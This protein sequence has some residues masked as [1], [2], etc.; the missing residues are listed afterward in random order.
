M[1]NVVVGFLHGDV[2]SSS[3]MMAGAG[4]TGEVFDF[5]VLLASCG[6]PVM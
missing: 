2:I 5:C 1:R 6:S 3:S 4:V